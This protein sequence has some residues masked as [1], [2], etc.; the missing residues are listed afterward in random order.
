MIACRPFRD[1]DLHRLERVD[2]A[3]EDHPHLL[4]RWPTERE[5]ILQYPL[6]KWLAGHRH[7]II[8]RAEARSD[9]ALARSG[10]RRDAVDHR[11]P[12]PM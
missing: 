1:A 11:L 3:G 7:R 9:G 8:G 4:Q 12:R 5:G 10:R 6:P 2:T